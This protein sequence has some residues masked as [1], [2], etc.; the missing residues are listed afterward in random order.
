MQSASCACGPK[1]R[2][3]R[4]SAAIAR[5][6]ISNNTIK[7]GGSAT[8]SFI[9]GDNN[10]VETTV[11]QAVS[12]PDPNTVRIADELAGLRAVLVTLKS[13][14]AAKLGRAAAAGGAA[15]R[16]LQGAVADTGGHRRRC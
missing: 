3:S 5:D 11:K 4:S 10:Q 12:L 1:Q 6:N 7:I 8:G 16:H 15:R 9:A 2:Q 14:E 13:P